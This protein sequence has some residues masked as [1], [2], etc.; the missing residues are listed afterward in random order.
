[1]VKEMDLINE[2]K[3]RLELLDKKMLEKNKKM[4]KITKRD[5]ETTMIPL[6][7]DS[8]FKSL[9]IKNKKYLKD[10]LLDVL[11][12]DLEGKD[13]E[14][15]ILNNEAV[16]DNYDE[17]QKIADIFLKLNDDILLNIE[18]SRTK[19][20]YRKLRNDRY[21]GK[22]MDTQIH[23]ESDYINLFYKKIIQLNINAL[24]KNK[25]CSEREIVQYDKVTKEIICE[26]PKVYIKYIENYRD[27]YYNG[28]RRR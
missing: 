9:F 4:H 3:K 6:T 16:K 25:L 7:F 8:M 19:Y 20:K 11:H 1:M 14:I 26:N 10:F 28:D 13:I 2:Y 17:Y 12:K 24:E 22:L 23:S 18:V 5:K 27:L 21:I 15:N